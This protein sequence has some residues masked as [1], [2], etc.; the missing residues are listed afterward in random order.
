MAARRKLRFAKPL[1]YELEH[2]IEQA[3]NPDSR[4]VISDR[5]DALGSL[6][7]DLDWRMSE[8]DHRTWRVGQ[9]LVG[10]ELAALGWGRMMPDEI[11]P[12]MSTP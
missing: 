11:T 6:I 5:R 9:E 10:A 2:H 4:I 1:Y 8:A 3:P 7:A 12:E